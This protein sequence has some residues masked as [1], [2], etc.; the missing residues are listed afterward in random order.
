MNDLAMSALIRGEIVPDNGMDAILR[1][2]SNGLWRWRWN[3]K[4]FLPLPYRTLDEAMGGIVAYANGHHR[5]FIYHEDKLVDVVGFNASWGRGY[6][7]HREPVSDD[8]CA[9]EIF[10]GS[11]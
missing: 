7:W 8:L 1:R 3:Y 5:A 6:S 4:E 2:Q 9:E 10:D 11:E